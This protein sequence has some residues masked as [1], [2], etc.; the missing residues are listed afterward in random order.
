M[1]HVSV[2]KEDVYKYLNLKK[3]EVVVD[4]TMGLG[5]HAGGILELIGGKGVLIGFDLDENNLKEAGKRLEHYK[6]KILINDNFRYLKTRVNEA[7]FAQVDAI[8]F[9]LGLSSPHVEVASRGFS[10]LKEGPLDMRFSSNQ[11]LTAYV[12]INQYPENKLADVIWRYGEERASRRIARKI[13]E[14]R[15]AKKFET[16]TEFAD[17]IESIAPARGGKKWRKSK[18]HPAT[19]IFQA[20]RI[21]VNDELN[22]L[23]EA[24]GYSIDLLKVGGRMV[25]ISY[26]SLEDRIVKHFF[27]ELA[28]SCVCPRELLV[29]QCAGEPAVELLTRKPVVPS[30]KEIAENP[31]ARSA[32]LRAIKKI[33]DL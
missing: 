16:T 25:V 26:H 29:C 7:G 5:G 24:L 3:G 32:K 23:K 12:V 13:V 1:Q 14:R 21:E 11:E 19:T 10:F 8:L 28:R 18:I 20:I 6:N 27:K 4:A 15:M 22:A 33:K 31:R 17:F 2:L 30:D 9:D